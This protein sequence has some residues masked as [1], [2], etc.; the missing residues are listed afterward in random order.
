MSPN[1]EAVTTAISVLLSTAPE[2]RLGQL[3]NVCLVAKVESNT[4][5]KAHQLF[6]DVDNLAHWIQEVIGDDGKYT[7]NEWQALGEMD[8]LE[9]IEAFVKGLLHEVEAL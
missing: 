9:N 5:A 6:Q 7:P 1:Q 3:F 8:L 4:K 2:T